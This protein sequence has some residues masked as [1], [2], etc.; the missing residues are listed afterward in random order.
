MTW[1]SHLERLITQHPIRMPDRLLLRILS[2]EKRTPLPP[3][4]AVVSAPFQIVR[5]FRQQWVDGPGPVHPATR[6]GIVP[7]FLHSP[8]LKR[9]ALDMA[10]ATQEIA[11]ALDGRAPETT[12]PVPAVTHKA[13]GPIKVVDVGATSR[14]TTSTD[15]RAVLVAPGDESD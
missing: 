7:V 11:L 4:A 6:P 14:P 3:T 15:Q 5:V 10:A 12:L 2:Q 1:E 8:G 9:A 13:I